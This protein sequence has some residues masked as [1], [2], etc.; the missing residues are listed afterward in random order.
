[1][2]SKK[3]IRLIY[4]FNLFN[5]YNLYGNNFNHICSVPL[6]VALKVIQLDKKQLCVFTKSTFIANHNFNEL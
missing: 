1:M 6:K 5:K 3:F 4:I 2:F